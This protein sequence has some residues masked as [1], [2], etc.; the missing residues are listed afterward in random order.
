MNI[1]N[2]IKMKSAKISPYHVLPIAVVVFV[3]SAAIV[4][5]HHWHAIAATL[6]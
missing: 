2:Y 3:V 6:R 4:L 1:K 5:V